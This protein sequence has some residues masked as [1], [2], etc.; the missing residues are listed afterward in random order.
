MYHGSR[1]ASLGGEGV[2]GELLGLRQARGVSGDGLRR[3]RI[4]R[5]QA[6]EA[7]EVEDAQRR[8]EPRAPA[9]GH[10]VARPGQVIAENLKRM[11]A[12]EQPARVFDF[13]NPRPRVAHGQAQMLRRII[14]GERDGLRE[15]AG[16]DDAGVALEGLGDDVGARERF[17]EIRDLRLDSPR[18]RLARSQQDG[19]GEEIVLGL[20]QQVGGDPRRVGE[21][22]GDDNGFGRASEA[23][24]ADDAVD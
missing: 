2:R 3:G 6:G 24:Y 19:R 13:G 9:R 8:G 10:H 22:V 18:Q 4:E 17:E 1:Q 5:H 20:R 23:V 15:V 12:E 14:V 21:F 11:L 16:E 7:H